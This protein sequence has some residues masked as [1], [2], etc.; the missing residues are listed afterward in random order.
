VA[1]SLAATC[2]VCIALAWLA[3]ELFAYGL[4]GNDVQAE[5]LS[6]RRHL[7]AVV[8]KRDCGAT[9]AS[10]THVSIIRSSGSVTGFPDTSGN[11]AVFRTT[12]VWVEWQSDTELVVHGDAPFHTMESRVRGVAIR[13]PGSWR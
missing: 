4:C 5:V 11:V 12:D 1:L 2:V 10:T 9:D 13:Y 6:P 8:F 7:K 3:L